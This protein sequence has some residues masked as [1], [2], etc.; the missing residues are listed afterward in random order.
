VFVGG[1][2]G[3]LLRYVVTEHWPVAPQ[4]FPWPT[5]AVNVGGAF[6]LALLV[7]VVVDAL[8]P[9]TYVRPL[10][11]TGFCGALTTFSSVVVDADRMIAHAHAL[12]AVAYLGASV[13]CGLAAVYIGLVGG[14]LFAGRYAGRRAQEGAL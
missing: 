10:V 4:A 13:G 7:V 8:G 5:F 9:S 3:G 14:R 2:V 11:G 6:V 12:T 1:C